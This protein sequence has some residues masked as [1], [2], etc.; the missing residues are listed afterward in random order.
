[1]PN[2]ELLGY[3]V[4]FKISVGGDPRIP[5]NYSSSFTISYHC[6]LYISLTTSYISPSRE[7]LPLGKSRIFLPFEASLIPK[8]VLTMEEGLGNF[9]N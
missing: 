2:Q 9:S 8:V 5:S 3:V 1:M 4:V 6:I 7:W